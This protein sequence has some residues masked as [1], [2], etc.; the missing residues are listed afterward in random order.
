MSELRALGKHDPGQL[1]PEPARSKVEEIVPG[2]GAL[3][4]PEKETGRAGA[5]NQHDNDLDAYYFLPH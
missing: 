4:S 2:E 1:V 5:A 3:E